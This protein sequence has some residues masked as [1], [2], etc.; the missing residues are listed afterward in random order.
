MKPAQNENVMSSI[1]ITYDVKETSD[2]VHTELKRELIETYKYS[3]KIY[4]SNGRWY[5]LPNTCLIKGG[6]TTQQASVDFLAACTKVKATWEKYIAVDYS[7]A[8]VNNQ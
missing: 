1:L 4:A 7:N 8:T 5:D 2:T 3:S 6:I